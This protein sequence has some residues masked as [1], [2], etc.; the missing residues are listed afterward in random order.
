MRSAS[1]WTRL[2]SEPAS[3]LFFRPPPGRYSALRTASVS[4]VK[5]EYY[6][7]SQDDETLGELYETVWEPG[8][9]KRAEAAQGIVLFVCINCDCN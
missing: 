3:S 6:H 4:L 5:V 1:G 8:M 9:E 7:I 2:G